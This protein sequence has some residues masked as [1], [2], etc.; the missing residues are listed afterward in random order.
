MNFGGGIS[1]L[2]LTNL[3][4][5]AFV[6]VASGLEYSCTGVSFHNRAPSHTITLFRFYEFLNYQLFK[7]FDL[8]KKD[9]K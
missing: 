2:E 5:G 3:M 1:S 7:L 4:A 9:R 6:Y 8:D